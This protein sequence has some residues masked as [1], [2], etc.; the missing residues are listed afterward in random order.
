MHGLNTIS[1]PCCSE[2]LRDIR[3]VDYLVSSV[4]DTLPLKND[5][6]SVTLGI[7]L[8]YIFVASNNDFEVAALGLSC[9]VEHLICQALLWIKGT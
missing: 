7:L 6:E 5:N 8:G 1:L 3:V 9:E 2:R 4:L